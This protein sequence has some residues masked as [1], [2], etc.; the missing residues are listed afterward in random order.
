MSDRSTI[1][2]SAAVGVS[3]IGSALG[4]QLLNLAGPVLALLV[5][6]WTEWRKEGYRKRVDELEI[7]VRDLRSRLDRA[8]RPSEEDLAWLREGERLPAPTGPEA[9]TLVSRVNSR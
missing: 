2:S 7:L 5:H 3:V 8:E 6:C 1:F 9:S 4:D